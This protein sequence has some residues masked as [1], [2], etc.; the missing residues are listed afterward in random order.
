MSAGVSIIICC[1]N[2]ESRIRGTLLA[3]AAQNST[4]RKE[5]VLVD[6]NCTDNTVS[7]AQSIWNETES[8]SDLVVVS[9][10]V[11]GLAHARTR[12]VQAAHFDYI[13]FCDDDNHLSEG[14][15]QRVFEV[16]EGNER[17]GLIGG[18]GV[19]K[20]E[21]HDLPPY[22][23]DLS[24]AFAVG[25]Q[26]REGINPNKF[27]LYGAGLSFRKDLYL[28]LINSEYKPLLVDRS[29]EQLSSGGDTELTLNL[30]HR[31][32][33]VY[34]SADLLFDH[35]ISARRFDL[36]YLK[37]LYQ[38]FGNAEPYFQLYHY[39]SD[40]TK[41][42][43]WFGLNYQ[44][45]LLYQWLVRWHARLLLNSKKELKLLRIVKSRSAVASLRSMKNKY[46]EI[47]SHII[48]NL[49]A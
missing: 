10:P 30:R 38:G 32:A 44:T 42:Y 28:D 9:E 41:P 45:Q 7:Q 37:K 24:E 21:N 4:I 33:L 46:S 14:Y 34:W 2:S 29:E 8:E 19:L 12:G 18:N 26:G 13:I 22:A 40:S 23:S 15:V 47:R 27:T 49:R 1:Y 11:P 16:F 3:L 20:S 36:D 17:V 48:R 6:N 31:G 39:L 25:P 5:V 35:V 43:G